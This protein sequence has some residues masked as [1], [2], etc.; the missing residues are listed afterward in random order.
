MPIF[1]QPAIISLVWLSLLSQILPAGEVRSFES[2]SQTHLAQAVRVRDRALAHTTQFLPVNDRQ[3]VVDGRFDVQTKRVL[4]LADESLRLVESSLQ[5]AVKLNVYLARTDDRVAFEKIWAAR[6]TANGNPPHQTPAVCFVTTAPPRA[7]CLVSLDVIATTDLKEPLTRRHPSYPGPEQHVAVLPRGGR[8]YVSGQAERGQDLAEATRLTLASLRKT[9][10]FLG[11]SDRDIVQVKSFVNPLADIDT[12][13]REIQAFYGSSV[14]P[15]AFVEWKLPQ[16][17]IEL[18][19]AAPLKTDGPHVEYITP[20]GMKSSPV[21]ARVTRIHRG[22]TIFVSGL[23]GDTSG[24]AAEEVETLFLRMDRLLKQAGSDL[25][26][27]TKATYYVASDETSKKL[28]ELRPKFY[29]PQRPPA[30]S[31]AI[32]AGVA[33]ADR[34]LVIDMI[35]TTIDEDAR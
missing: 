2:D 35:A 9:L 7:G 32:V 20:P 22:P 17:E 5:R 23:Y 1:Q 8:M 30:A 21:F 33:R 19:V 24:N 26:H 18:V 29:D 4:D 6:V 14:P 34:E 10:T 12:V 28:N 25:K 27:L 16:I 31:K 15:W 3:E 13:S 11:L